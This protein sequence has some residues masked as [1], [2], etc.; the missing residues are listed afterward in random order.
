MQVGDRQQ[1]LLRPI[2]RAVGIGGKR[3]VGNRNVMAGHSR[4]K[5]GVALLAYVR[6]ISL[7]RER[8]RPGNGITGTRAFGAAR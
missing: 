4:S 7:R 6:A 2:Q 8:P 3:N 5:N 1:P